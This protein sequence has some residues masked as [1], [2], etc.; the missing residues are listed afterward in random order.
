[1]VVRTARVTVVAGYVFMLLLPGATVFSKIVCSP[2][3]RNSK[4]GTVQLHACLQFKRTEVE[5][6]RQQHER[7]HERPV[8]RAPTPL[9]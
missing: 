3:K 9:T 5:L 7:K 8:Y 1:M 6:K 2:F 4:R